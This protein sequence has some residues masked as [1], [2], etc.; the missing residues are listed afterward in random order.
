MH[1]IAA[2][3]TI[4]TD[5]KGHRLLLLTECPERSSNETEENKVEFCWNIL[6]AH[7]LFYNY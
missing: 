7:N 2:A 3:A 6:S 5:R 4:T 1:F